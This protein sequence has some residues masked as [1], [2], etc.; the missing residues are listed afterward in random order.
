MKPIIFVAL[1]GSLVLGACATSND[2]VYTQFFGGEVQQPLHD[3]DTVLT[4][5][6]AIGGHNR[7][8]GES[9][10]EL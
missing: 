10:P 5:C 7:F 4:P 8:V 2:P 6:S 9:Y 3:E 1:A